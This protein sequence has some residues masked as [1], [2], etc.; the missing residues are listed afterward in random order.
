MLKTLSSET[1]DLTT[2]HNLFN[3]AP[4]DIS[5]APSM[6]GIKQLV[7]ATQVSSDNWFSVGNW[8]H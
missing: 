8:S 5:N 6:L 2:T 7:H 1:A 3:L 4:G